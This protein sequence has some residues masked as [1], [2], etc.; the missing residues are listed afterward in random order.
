MAE[1]TALSES[2]FRS[3]EAAEG[4]RAFAEKRPPAWATDPTPKGR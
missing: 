2:L 1:M 4:M 3:E